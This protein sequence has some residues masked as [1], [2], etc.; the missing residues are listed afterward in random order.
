MLHSSIKVIPAGYETIGY[1]SGIKESVG[2][3]NPA[4]SQELQHKIFN[5]RAYIKYIFECDFGQK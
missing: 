3:H 5:I 2:L 4:R 1:R